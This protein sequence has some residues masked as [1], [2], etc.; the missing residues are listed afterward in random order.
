MFIDENVYHDFGKPHLQHRANKISTS[1]NKSSKNDR[2]FL[3]LMDQKTVKIDG[4]YE[5]LLPLKDEGISSN[6]NQVIRPVLN[7]FFFLR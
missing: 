4:N 1:Y 6:I 3:N 2:R 5:L 7:C